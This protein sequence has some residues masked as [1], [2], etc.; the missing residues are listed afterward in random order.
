MLAL[1]RADRECSEAELAIATAEQAAITHLRLER[2]WQVRGRSTC[3]NRRNSFDRSG[4]ADLIGK[5][6]PANR[7][8]KAAGPARGCL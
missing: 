2:L 6:T 4:A 5:R 8:S 7:A 3:I 1:S